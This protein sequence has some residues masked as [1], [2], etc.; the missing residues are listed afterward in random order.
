MFGVGKMF[1]KEVYCAHQGWI[2]LIKCTVQTV[3][4]LNLN[5]AFLKNLILTPDIWTAHV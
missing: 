1:L 3:L 5:A 4:L 2:D